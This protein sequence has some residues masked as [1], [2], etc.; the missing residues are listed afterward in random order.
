MPTLSLEG[1]RLKV[2]FINEHYRHCEIDRDVW[3]ALFA[4]IM[5]APGYLS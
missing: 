5:Q 3:E 4:D 1:I 2:E